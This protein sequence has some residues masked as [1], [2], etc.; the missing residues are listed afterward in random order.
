MRIILLF[1][2][3]VLIIS[4]M[5]CSSLPIRNKPEFDKYYIKKENFHCENDRIYFLKD[6]ITEQE[7]R[8]LIFFSLQNCYEPEKL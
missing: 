5:G 2:I 7:Y 8:Q 1:L 6:R 4:T 3:I